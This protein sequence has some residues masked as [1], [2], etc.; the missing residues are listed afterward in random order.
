MLGSACVR[1]SGF[2]A[3]QIVNMIAAET[4][5]RRAVAQAESQAGITAGP[6]VVTAQFEGLATQTFEARP[7]PGQALILKEDAADISAAVE[8]NCLQAERK[9]LHMF[10][11]PGRDDI[12]G[13]QQ[14]SP[15][16]GVDVIAI[17]MPFMVSASGSDALRQSLLLLMVNFIYFMRARTEERHLS[18]DPTYV[19][20]A[21][22]IA[23]RG[24]FAFLGRWFPILRFGH[25]RL[26]FRGEGA[27]AV[28]PLVSGAS[29]AA[30]SVA[31]SV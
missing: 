2:S 27:P 28:E 3:G 6:V 18:W 14:A 7:G 22:Y 8:E 5:I 15:P 19:A 4:S 21:H 1:S 11:A 10:T 12:G 29:T 9:L 16:N 20:Y 30:K 24:T 23:E 17:S 26:F 31:K 25:G 13:L